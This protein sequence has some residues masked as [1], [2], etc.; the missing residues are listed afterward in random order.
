MIKK[1]VSDNN[2]N[3]LYINKNFIIFNLFYQKY[4]KNQN[5]KYENYKINNNSN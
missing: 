1:L 2:D 3:D 4:Q 5:L